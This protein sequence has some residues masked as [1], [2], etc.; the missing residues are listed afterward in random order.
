MFAFATHRSAT[1]AIVDEG[2]NG[3]L[4]HALFVA[5]DDIGSI[6]LHQALE[7]I[8]AVDDAA[9]QVVEV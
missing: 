3:F 1:A 6:E 5:H 4:E 8:V 2:I 7:T 9:I